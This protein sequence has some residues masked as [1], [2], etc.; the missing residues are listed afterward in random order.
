MGVTE[1]GVCE[2]NY[3]PTIYENYGCWYWCVLVE[4]EESEVKK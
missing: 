4:E 1:H 3:D 2:Y